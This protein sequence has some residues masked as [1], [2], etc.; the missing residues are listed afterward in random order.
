M[1]LTQL[2]DLARAK[3]DEQ[4]AGFIGDVELD[5]YLN[6]GLKFIYG[7]IV[8]RFEDFFIVRGTTANGGLFTQVSG[9]DEYP[10]PSTLQKLVLVQMRRAG[11]TSNDAWIRLDRANIANNGID[12]YYPLREDLLHKVGYFLA[13]NNIY[14]RPVP[15]EAAEI[16]MWFV[17]RVT[18]L[19]SASDIPGIP[20]EYHELLSEYAAIQCLRKSGEGIFAESYKIWDQEL[21]NMLETVEVRD[22]QP[23]QMMITEDYEIDHYFG[24]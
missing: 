22:Q 7:K 6:Q 23:S 1:T 5:S 11:T 10:L 14:F 20:N 16:R 21:K 3:A 4:S 8:Q 12:I 13:G 15:A 18:A 19:A 17:P 9:T 2:R 24:A